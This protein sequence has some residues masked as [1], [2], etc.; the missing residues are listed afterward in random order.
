MSIT[1]VFVGLV[2]LGTAYAAEPEPPEN[3]TP[4]TTTLAPAREPSRGYRGDPG[5]L[6]TGIPGFGTPGA[7]P[8]DDDGSPRPI[9][10]PPAH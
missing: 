3:T 10:P 6:P 2:M 1:T 7:R 4:T 9:T 8:P 5:N